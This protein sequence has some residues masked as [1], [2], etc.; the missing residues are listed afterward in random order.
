M[1]KRV[2]CFFTGGY[3]ESNAMPIFLRKINN[4]IEFKQFCPNRTKRRK[5]PGEEADL[6]D[7][8]S[9]L[10]GS[11]LLKYVYSY[12]DNH[13]GELTDF[14]AVIIE[15]DLDGRFTETPGGFRTKVSKRTVDFQKH[16]DIVAC[17]V[18]KKLHKNDTFPVIQIFAA[19]EIET[20]FLS[21]WNNTFGL[22]YGPKF[23]SILSSKEN[24]YFSTMFQP[25]IRKNV[26]YGYADQI[27]NYGYFDGTYHKLSSH[28]S[29]AFDSFK[30][31]I[32]QYGSIAASIAS[33]A[34]LK[35][36]KRSHGDEMLR[37]LSPDTVQEKCSIYFR[38]AFNLIKNL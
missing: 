9:G 22:V 11:D 15:D 33:K 7:E 16:Y 4:G 12:L 6:I 38:E 24:Q 5:R 26:L 8:F 30:V 21:D 17:E 27:E 36:S 34:D 1:V 29:T 19:P 25:Y 23:F 28:I 37:H 32:A 35:Y 20:W 3:T 18:R 10:T 31:F 14:D 13:P 2:A